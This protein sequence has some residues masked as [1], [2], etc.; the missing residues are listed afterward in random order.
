LEHS[1]GQQARDH[2]GEQA[3]LGRGAGGDRE[4]HGER[5]GDHRHGQ[6]GDQIGPKRLEAVPFAQARDELRREQLA[7]RWLAAGCGRIGRRCDGRSLGG[8]LN[9]RY[10]A[11]E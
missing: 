9:L 4:R 1:A 3:A 6:A 2:R 11:R 5:Q 10:R 8:A 7:P